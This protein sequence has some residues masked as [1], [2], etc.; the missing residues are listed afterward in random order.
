V[1]KVLNKEER[2]FNSNVQS[3][4]VYEGLF[5]SINAVSSEFI[6]ENITEYK[7]NTDVRSENQLSLRVR[8]LV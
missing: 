3:Y 1:R 2:D 4:T 5:K 6:V 8:R 7:M